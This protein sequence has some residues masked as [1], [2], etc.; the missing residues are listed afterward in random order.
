MP[1]VSAEKSTAVL[2]C[3][4]ADGLVTDAATPRGRLL[5]AAAHLFASKG[6]ER[7]TVRDLAAAV[8][9]QSGSIF[10]HFK[11]KDE[12]LRA[13]MEETI[14]CNTALMRAA[15]EGLEDP[16]QRLLALIRCELHSIMG[17]TGEAMSVLVYEW[18]S[19]SGEGQALILSLRDCYEA[20]WLEV[21][22]QARSAG[23]VQV[24]PFILRR[25]L[26]GA[27][28]W[29]ITWFRPSGE[30]SVDEL[31]DQALKMLLGAGS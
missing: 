15:L 20:L 18:R 30:M 21:L 7:T 1:S 14:H 12:I 16:Q 5:Q 31:A 17:G 8:G 28:S 19:L 4:V 22:E 24:E 23:L 26:T 13:V 27:L 25:L 2:A 9:I 11:S 10:H 3:L 6:F 29:T